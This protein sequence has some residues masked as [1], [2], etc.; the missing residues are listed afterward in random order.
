MGIPLYPESFKTEK[1]KKILL[2]HKN[3]PVVEIT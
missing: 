2:K 3:G 1:K